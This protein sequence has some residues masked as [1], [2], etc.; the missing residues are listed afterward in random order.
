MRGQTVYFLYQKELTRVQKRSALSPHNYQATEI[1][2]CKSSLTIF[3]LVI[4][5]SRIV[6]VTLFNKVATS[7]FVVFESNF[8]WHAI[9]GTFN[10]LVYPCERQY[11]N[12]L[13]KFCTSLVCPSSVRQSWSLI[14]FLFNES[15]TFVWTSYF[16]VWQIVFFSIW[17][18]YHKNNTIKNI[19]VIIKKL[20]EWNCKGIRLFDDKFT[21]QPLR[22]YSRWPFMSL[23]QT[24]RR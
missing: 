13:Y 18:I 14:F 23:N 1:R 22:D 19:I 3:L 2:Q 8:N 10:T 15:A 7:L 21:S 24:Q 17:G 16:S 12:I 4:F 6:Q 20:K 9:G 5:L 11:F